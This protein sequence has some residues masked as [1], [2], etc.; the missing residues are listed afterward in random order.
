MF[1][2]SKEKFK[3]AYKE[4]M[5]RDPKPTAIERGKLFVTFLETM[6]FK[7]MKEV[8]YE[9]EKMATLESAKTKICKEKKKY[10]DS[11]K[12][13]D[14]NM[15]EIQL[16]IAKSE[17]GA[18]ETFYE[19]HFPVADIRNI[20]RDK[21]EEAPKAMNFFGDLNEGRF[22]ELKVSIEKQGILHN[23]VVQEL[24]NGNFRILSGHQRVRACDELFEETQDAKYQEF[25]C[26][27]YKKDDL[28]EE[29]ARRIV[30]LT[31]TAQRGTLSLPEQIRSISEL[32]ELEKKKSF[33]GSGDVT[34]EVAKRLNL[35]RSAVFRLKNLGNLIVPLKNECGN[36]KDG[37]TLSLRDGEVISYL[38]PE[39]QKHIYDKGYYQSDFLTATRVK[40]LRQLLTDATV[41]DVD[42]IFAG[43]RMYSYT[44]T[45]TVEQPQGFKTL[46]VHVAK[47]DELKL[48]QIIKAA[49]D[50]GELTASKEVLLKQVE[51]VAHDSIE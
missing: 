29:D 49:L 10:E 43:N 5:S 35:S 4:L 45:T 33:Y 13:E 18:D 8:L 31:N 14:A 2:I 3:I 9:V 39:L 26:K 48:L 6:S 51:E 16:H 24:E 21:L 1:D 38:T 22:T 12:K 27:V 50:K 17:A 11:L 47:E 28:S 32:T 20:P 37:K 42:K 36:K 46:A 19:S 30:I 44:I 40:A 7:D 15:D 23:L 41:E 34:T 25:P